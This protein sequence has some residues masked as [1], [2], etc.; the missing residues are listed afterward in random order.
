MEV[1]SEAGNSTN[2]FQPQRP[3]ESFLLEL[4]NKLDKKRS[5][6]EGDGEI[7]IAAN[8]S[9]MHIICIIVLSSCK[10]HLKMRTR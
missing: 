2:Q 4:Q 9:E 8:V 1:K 6:N 5:A 10:G 7:V 3:A